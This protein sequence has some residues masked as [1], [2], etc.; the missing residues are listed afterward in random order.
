MKLGGLDWSDSGQVQV[1]STCDAV[2]NI[3]VPLNSGK[4]SSGYTNC[5]LSSGAQHHRVS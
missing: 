1:E 2:M 4:L 5:G 3:R